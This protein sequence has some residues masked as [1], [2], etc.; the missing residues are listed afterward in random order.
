MIEYSCTAQTFPG[1]ARAPLEEA[2]EPL[3]EVAAVGDAGELLE[4]AIE[5]MVEPVDARG[6]VDQALGDGEGRRRP[7]GQAARRCR[8]T[9]ASKRVDGEHAVDEAEL[10]RLARRRGA[11]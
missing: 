4:L 3:G 8:R 10:E 1:S 5:M 6:L 11:G 2:R 9:S 7:G